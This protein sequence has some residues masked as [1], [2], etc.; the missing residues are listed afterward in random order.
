MYKKIIFI[1]LIAML[2]ACSHQNPLGSSDQKTTAK[3][4]VS[5]SQYAEQ[6]LGAFTPPGGYVYGKCMSGKEKAA[7]CNKLYQQMLEFAK[8]EPVYQNL[9]L[10]DLTDKKTWN[11]LKDGYNQERFNTI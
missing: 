8:N 10:A 6:K 7:T 11:L 9:S 2:T 1:G 3:F 5:A 4:L